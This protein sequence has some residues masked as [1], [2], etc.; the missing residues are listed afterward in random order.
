MRIETQA[1]KNKVSKTQRSKAYL[2]LNIRIVFGLSNINAW[3][4][5]NAGHLEVH[6]DP[7]CRR[8]PSGMNP[9]EVDN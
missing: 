2:T 6:H 3:V 9:K 8:I 4:N 7:P 1:L 5:K